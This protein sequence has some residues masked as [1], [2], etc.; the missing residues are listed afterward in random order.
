MNMNEYQVLAQ[1]TA[2]ITDT[3]ADKLLNGCMGLNGEAGECIDLL[4]KHLFQ[5][6]EL[7]REKLIEEL[8]DVLWYCA[9]L[10]AG[11]DVGLAEV[12]RRN[13]EKLRRRY[14]KFLFIGHYDKMVMPHGEE[15][16]RRE[17][18]RLLPTMRQGG[19]LPSVDHQTPPGVSLENYQI[20]VRL[21]KEYAEKT[22]K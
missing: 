16:M 3:T 6:H 12:A 19:F 15:A 2:A 10:A 11:L 8:G 5:G 17:F 4:K 9:E 7:D 20:Y 18:E 14:P 13:I 1:V 21:L 22:V